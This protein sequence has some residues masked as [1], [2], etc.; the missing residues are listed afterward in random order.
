MNY[1]CMYTYMNLFSIEPTHSLQ[2]Q[3]K[4]NNTRYCFDIIFLLCG[5]ALIILLLNDLYSYENSFIIIQ[6]NLSRC[7]PD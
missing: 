2:M 4:S 1:E 6:S 7:K 5:S 3:P